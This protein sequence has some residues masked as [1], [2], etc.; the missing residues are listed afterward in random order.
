MPTDEPQSSKIELIC[1]WMGPL[2]IA[3]FVLGWMLL[4]D[5]FLPPVPS[6]TPAAIADV[7]QQN[8][9]NIRLGMVLTQYAGALTLPFAAVITAVMLRMKGTSPALAY[10]QFGAAVIN[11]QIF[12]IPAQML[13]ATAYRPD[14]PFEIT[15]F[16]FDMGMLTFDSTAA[17]AI[18]QFAVIGIAILSERSAQPTFPRWFAYICFWGGL[19]FI[20]S[21]LVTF[22]KQGPFTWSGLLGWYLGLFVYCAW[23]LVMFPVLLKAVKGRSAVRSP[24]HLAMENH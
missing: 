8:T 11:A 12:I 1:A 16:G 19:L 2:A 14:R 9:F 15:Q 13:N 10:T 21:S 7:F 4:A 3:L 17:A 23:F 22:F 24:S 5:W 20:P 18:L 6:L